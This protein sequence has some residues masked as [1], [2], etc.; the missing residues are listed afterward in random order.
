MYQSIVLTLL[1]FNIVFYFAADGQ[2]NSDNVCETKNDKMTT[3]NLLREQSI[4]DSLRDS[5]M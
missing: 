3:L 4:A 2:N 1:L 5:S